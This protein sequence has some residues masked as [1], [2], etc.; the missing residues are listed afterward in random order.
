MGFLYAALRWSRPR[1]VNRFFGKLQIGSAAYMGFAH[2]LADAQKTMGVITLALV[3]A[4]AAG[5]FEQLPSWL[6]FLRMDKS[7]AAEACIVEIGRKDIGGEALRAAAA[8]LEAEALKIERGEFRVRISCS[9]V[10]LAITCEAGGDV[11]IKVMQ[12][13][14]VVSETVKQPC[15]GAACA[16]PNL[17]NRDLFILG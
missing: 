13:V 4:T 2:G 17:E 10:S 6:S 11:R 5:S 8:G 7:A 3:S 9:V 16:R 15:A 1:F 14:R 12:P